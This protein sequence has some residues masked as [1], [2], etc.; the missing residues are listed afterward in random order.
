MREYT[1]AVAVAR[2]TGVVRGVRA[3]RD[4]GLHRLDDRE[5]HLGGGRRGPQRVH[6]Q[7]DQRGVQPRAAGCGDAREARL[8]GPV[9]NESAAI[10][11]KQSI[12][13]NDALRTGAYGTTLT[14][15]LSTTTP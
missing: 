5:R 10:G 15:T 6:G 9:S 7:A 1:D 14:F 4:E 2:R 8:D 12:A 11:F 3:R 13:A